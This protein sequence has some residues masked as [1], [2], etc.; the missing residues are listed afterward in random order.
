[1]LPR[2]FYKDNQTVRLERTD[3]PT[4]ML[5]DPLDLIK[6]SRPWLT[7]QSP[8]ERS[9][10]KKSLIFADAFFQHREKETQDQINEKLSELREQGFVIYI[11]LPEGLIKQWDGHEVPTDYSLDLTQYTEVVIRKQA[12]EQHRLPAASF[13]SLDYFGINELLGKPRNYFKFFDFPQPEWFVELIALVQDGSEIELYFQEGIRLF[14]K[15]VDLYQIDLSKFNSLTLIG[16]RCDDL[17][18]E[19]VQKI[20]AYLDKILFDRCDD[21]EIFLKNNINFFNKAKIRI[22][23]EDLNLQ[24]KDILLQAAPQLEELTIDYTNNIAGIFQES[25]PGQLRYLKKILVTNITTADI[26][27]LLEAAPHLEEIDL[28]RCQN[29]AG[30]LQ[31]CKS[32]QLEYLKKIFVS[33]T[34]VTKA[35]VSVLLKVAPQLEEINLC[36]VK[37]MAGLF[38][39]YKPGQLPYLKKISLK[40]T[41]ITAADMVALLK[42]APY[43]EEI[44]LNGCQNIAGVLQ[45]CK[46]GQLEYLKNISL[47]NAN[48]TSA[49][50]I[51]LLKVACHLEKIGANYSQ[52][53]VNAL[54]EGKLEQLKYL[55]TV[56]LCNIDIQAT[57][58]ITLLQLTPQLKEINF[59]LSNMIGGTLQQYKTLKFPHLTKISFFSTQITLADAIVLLNAAPELEEL[60]F[61]GCENL[62]NG[63]KEYKLEQLPRLKKVK[64]SYSNIAGENLLALMNAAPNLKKITLD[65]YANIAGAFAQC[66]PNQFPHL[67]AIDL[68]YTYRA[69][70][71]A[72]LIALSAAAPL[73]IKAI[74]LIKKLI[75]NQKIPPSIP[76]AQHA[77]SQTIEQPKSKFKPQLPNSF[78]DIIEH[79]PTH[80]FK[81]Y[82]P[83]VI[84]TIYRL[85][86]WTPNLDTL[87]SPPTEVITDDFKPYTPDE[88]I[89]F[90][91][92]TVHPGEINFEGMGIILPSL[93]GNEKLFNVQ[94]C[95]HTGKEVK[96]FELQ[97]SEKIGFYRVVLPQAGNYT[98][99]Y[100]VAVPIN[101]PQLPQQIQELVKKYKN[102]QPS[103]KQL[104]KMKSLRDLKPALDQYKTGRCELRA[105]AAYDELINDCNYSTTR[106]ML[107]DVHAYVEI[108][109]K[110]HYIKLNLGG[111]AATL[112]KQSMPITS[113]KFPKASL[114]CSRSIKTAPKRVPTFHYHLDEMKL[115]EKKIDNQTSLMIIDS[116][117]ALRDFLSRYSHA[118]T[119]FVARKPED[120]NLT[121]SGM[122]ADGKIIP[123]HTPFRTWLNQQ[124]HLS[125]TICVDMR[126]FDDGELAQLNSLLDRSLDGETISPQIQ[127]V[128]VDDRNRA[129]Y[130][131]D[132]ERRVRIKT[133]FE[134]KDSTLLAP[135][136]ARVIETFVI[137]LFDSPYWQPAL[138]GSWQL[139][140]EIP[141]SKV[142][143]VS[144]EKG[145][146]LKWA[147]GVI[148]DHSRPRLR[149]D[150]KVRIVFKNPPLYDPS[151]TAFIAE[152]QSLKR[153]Q[154]ADQTTTIGEE[155]QFYQATGY[156]W[157]ELIQQGSV[158]QLR[159]EDE[160][161]VLSNASIL[162][163]IQNPYYQFSKETDQLTPTNSHLMR[164]KEEKQCLN[165]M[166]T[167][168]ITTSTVAQ[169]LTEAKK[170]DVQV[171][172]LLPSLKEV[173][174]SALSRLPEEKVDPILEEKMSKTPVCQWY[175]AKDIEFLSKQLF[176]A[177]KNASCFDLSCLSSAELGRFPDELDHMQKRFMETGKF[178]MKAPLS[179][180]LQKLKN[181]ETVILSGKIS[182]MLYEA[183]MRLTLGKIEG[184]AYSGKLMIIVPQ[185]NFSVAKYIAA[186]ALIYPS[187][188]SEEEKMTLL[189]SLYPPALD[190]KY[191]NSSQDFSALEKS[192][193]QSQL[194]HLHPSLNIEELKR[195]DDK[196]R[197]LAID[198]HR[199]KGVNHALKLNPW[200]MLEGPTGI[201]K[202]Y[203]LQHYLPK[204]Q[205]EQ[206]ALPVVYQLEDWLKNPSI[207]VVDEAS[208]VSQLSR[209]GENFL[210]RFK[211]LRNDPP[212]FLWKGKYYELSK[213]HKVIFAFN[214]ASY[215]AGR[216][217]T[218]FLTDQAL[219]VSFKA[220]PDFY[221]K[222]RLITPLLT[223]LIENKRI[224][225]DN[226][227]GPFLD[228]YRWICN[229]GPQNEILITPREIKLMVNLIASKIKY[230]NISDETVIQQ[231][232]QEIAFLVG[233]QVLSERVDSH[234]L[235][236]FDRC[237]PLSHMLA[238]TVK[239]ESSLRY[240]DYQRE[241]YC[242]ITALLGMD[243]VLTKHH[244][245]PGL[246]GILLE[247]ASGTG[248]TYFLKAIAEEARHRGKKVYE[249]SPNTS[250]HEKEKLLHQAFLE[251]AW[252]IADEFNTSLWPNKLLNNYLMS[253]DEHGRPSDLP[254]LKFLATQNPP[255]FKGRREADPALAARFFKF[256][257]NW[258]VYNELLKI[259]K[260]LKNTLSVLLAQG[261][262]LLRQSVDDPR[263]F[264]KAYSRELTE[265][266]IDLWKELVDG[267]DPEKNDLTL[268]KAKMEHLLMQAFYHNVLITRAYNQGNDYGKLHRCLVAT[269]N[270][271][272]PE[273]LKRVIE[274]VIVRFKSINSDDCI[275]A[276]DLVWQ[277]E[278]P[279]LMPRVENVQASRP[280]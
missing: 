235:A 251:K 236:E 178:A 102:Y 190:E 274:G 18:K 56:T 208:F 212:G 145:E 106:I 153:I 259:R 223:D 174:L 4:G 51:T 135:L 139:K 26:V 33:D 170:H 276:E 27:A 119:V 162:G 80:T 114:P 138:I 202:T 221:I 19:L 258:P 86:P 265:A 39:E 90:T 64:F 242:Q 81:E 94:I 131:P 55:K 156:A 219:H 275:K 247:G 222:V 149:A 166:C 62:N 121:S 98:I 176:A 226:I 271:S 152:L 146:L 217:T 15:W 257:V 24:E 252:V 31:E 192:Y 73:A 184:E 132:F 2:N 76:N 201:G 17:V 267:L 160:P 250:Y 100:Q 118:E 248:K 52:N 169:L 205:A 273:M 175:V 133:P 84:P 233:R 140:Q 5:N 206:K 173:K 204:K 23:L 34:N 107:N 220:L 199:F 177:N 141:D 278:K 128:L 187:L 148:N 161:L 185:E 28:N 3:I 68:P 241:V 70:T 41:N 260:L 243:N 255:S 239:I 254:A 143:S 47:E 136:P 14:L 171:R 210:E 103:T 272:Q 111:Y 213:E 225:L 182:P 218:G 200:V 137:D 245:D 74:N 65:R 79:K 109:E 66:Q 261:E 231:L 105:I 264:S 20:G 186:D 116:D 151:F 95:D 59:N 194:D 7:I 8:P 37:N 130:G 158:A 197:A 266:R 155:V 228:V 36:G 134:A 29:I 96:T 108:R 44:D 6:S 249:I 22:V 181:G 196:Q 165:V 110:G 268:N 13:F 163:F 45:E 164:C 188:P 61:S 97:R 10:I 198:E 43:L 168:D 88:K 240:P 191:L 263:F 115:D 207:L 21:V 126:N 230:G 49:D 195:L 72:D 83:G 234:L 112:N 11:L 189:N 99:Y 270:K 63:S 67:H 9:L 277:K 71:L 32:G 113:P 183:L 211:G 1:M 179:S 144:W 209:E 91:Q 69:V 42:A 167:Y 117:A 280:G 30:A 124:T 244:P 256:K 193:H 122:T 89:N 104:P 229:H 101:K 35:D 46:P 82:F 237:K 125:A 215:G 154:W 75:L 157:D 279:T 127:I 16:S 48:I 25:K 172:F 50:A 12:Y 123:R 60:N 253:L 224:N 85:I 147:T 142:F 269:L 120:L 78:F 53:T 92:Y 227:A 57:D 216:S 54:Q 246:G 38:Q 159:D 77:A 93:D 87:D 180:L 238:N 262:T 150:G 203:F 232:A 214:P 40:N 129:G 58:I